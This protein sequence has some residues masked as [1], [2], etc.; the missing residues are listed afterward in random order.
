MA[1]APGTTLIDYI[2][3]AAPSRSKA[4]LKD[5]ALV[6]GASLL[7]ALSAKASIHVPFSPIPFTLQ[8]LVVMLVAATLGSRRGALA[9]ILYL[10]EGA[11]GLPIFASGGGFMYLFL[12]PSAGYLW[13][14]PIAAFVV[15]YL[16]ERG[17]DRK[18]STSVLA[19]LPGTLIIYALGVSWLA[20]IAHL[21]LPQAIVAGMLP[22]IPFDLTKI[23]IAAILMPVAWMVIRRVKSESDFDR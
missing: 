7:M 12:S 10:A 9:M 19:M 3:P 22:Y 16:C 21:T 4:L 15:G 14:Y 8:T 6:I 17:L 2:S 11:T 5:G 23:V 1:I 18:L 13:S 20:M